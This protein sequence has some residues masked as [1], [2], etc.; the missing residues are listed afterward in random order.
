MNTQNISRRRCLAVVFCALIVSA[1]LVNIDI[2]Q[3]ITNSNRGAKLPQAYNESSLLQDSNCQFVKS[4]QEID[5]IVLNTSEKL[6]FA[7]YKQRK[8]EAFLKEKGQRF[9]KKK[10]FP[11][12]LVEVWCIDC[13]EC[14]IGKK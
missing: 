14:L 6:T 5:L 7:M 9:R 4:V 10:N 13:S 12:K 11:S 2:G 3:M 8:A 1:F